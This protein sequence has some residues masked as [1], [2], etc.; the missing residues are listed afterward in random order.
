MKQSI[1]ELVDRLRTAARALN[2]TLQSEPQIIGEWDVQVIRANGSVERKTLRNTVTAA[3]LNRLA[4]RAVQATG[5]S[6]FFV[7]CVGSN[8]TAPALTDVQSNMG[9]MLRKSF[10]AAG[11]SAQSREWIF[12]VCTI[13][14]AADGV[15]SLAMDCA[16]LFDLTTSHATNG[17]LANRVNG[18]A[19][20][21]G[22]SD[23]LNLTVRIR[24]GSHNLSHS[25]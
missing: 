18:L 10:I 12:G 11:A 13:G 14:G 1:F 17:V 24:C 19:V 8:T 21:L 25:T 20:T 3:G 6:V 7:I 9:E 2:G 15:T 23:F 5:T 16:G 22:N 4:N